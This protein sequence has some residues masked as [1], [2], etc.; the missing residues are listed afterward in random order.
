MSQ[1]SPPK[2][3]ARGLSALYVSTFLSGAWAMIIPT[4]PVLAR[5][6]DVSADPHAEATGFP[7][8]SDITVVVVPEMA[9]MHNFADTRHRLWRRFADWLPVVARD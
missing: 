9:H 1:S 7:A 6:F 8:S 4:I 2:P 5:E 3:S